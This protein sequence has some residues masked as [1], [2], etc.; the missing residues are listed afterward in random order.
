MDI[1]RKD[2]ILCIIFALFFAAGFLLCVFYPKENYSDSERRRLSAMPELSAKTV[3]NG[4]FMSGFETFA[5]DTFPFREQLRTVKALTAAEIFRRGDN[6]GIYVSEGFLS[7]LEYPM[8]TAS[9]DRALL[10]FRYVCGKYLTEENRVF[11]SVIPDKNCF[12]AKESGRPSMDYQA[13]EDYV[14]READFAEYITISDLLKKEDYY[15]TDTHWRQERI[16]DVAKRLAEG[17]GAAL[18]EEYVV[19]T[20][21]A[22]FYGVYY[23]QAALP[24]VPDEIKYLT[25]EA[26]STCKVYDWQNGRDIPVY[27]MEKAE[28]KDPYEMFLS[29]PLSLVTIENPLA[30]EG[31]RLIIFRDS[32]GSA[33]APLLAS[34]YSEITLADIRYMNPDNLGKFVDFEGCDVLFLYSTLVL[35][36]S[37]T[38]K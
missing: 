14:K 33:M 8:N 9:L 38:L 1:R 24:L 12:L 25:G 15:K 21:D 37:E 36:N 13:F 30:R 16:A 32:F 29:G 31:K 20:L 4:R 7:K 27:S 6:N 2:K 35:N 3:W 10:R 23:G 5:A 18:L 22:D 26:I 19:H 11:L 34:G 17:M 28:G